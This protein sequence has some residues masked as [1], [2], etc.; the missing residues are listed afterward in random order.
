MLKRYEVRPQ[1]VTVLGR[2]LQGYRQE[3]LWDAWERYL[4][5]LDPERTELAELPESTTAPEQAT[6]PKVPDFQLPGRACPKCN[7]EGCGWCG[8]WKPASEISKE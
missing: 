4:H 6:V 3:H 8:E 5:P 2:S 1:K 7:G